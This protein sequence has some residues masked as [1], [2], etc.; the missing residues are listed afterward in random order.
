METSSGRAGD[1]VMAECWLYYLS[2]VFAG[3][4]ATL[5]AFKRRSPADA[6]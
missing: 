4:V 2:G 1:D 5:I 3:T 6:A